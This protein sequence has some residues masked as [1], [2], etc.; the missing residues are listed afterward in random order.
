M[1]RKTTHLAE[2]RGIISRTL[3]R[4]KLS[5]DFPRVLPDTGRKREFLDSR[6]MRRY[7]LRRVCVQRD[8]QQ[9]EESETRA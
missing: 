2:E 3:A 8:K 1:S 7:R 6:D 5:K 4:L 9:R